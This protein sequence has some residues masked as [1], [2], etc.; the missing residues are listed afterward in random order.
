MSTRARAFERFRYISACALAAVSCTGANGPAQPTL[1]SASQTTLSPELAASMRSREAVLGGIGLSPAD[2]TF[3]GFLP[4]GDH[5]TFTFDIA[6]DQC[7]TFVALTTRNTRDADAALYT[8]DGELLAVDSETDSHPTIQACAPE[9]SARLYYVIQVVEGDGSFLV[10]P[11]LGTVRQLPAAARALGGRPAF[12]A[13]V[14]SSEL[15]NDDPAATLAEGLRKRGYQAIGES[16]V[17]VLAAKERIRT[18]LPVEHG[19]CYTVAAFGSAGVED[20]GL[21]VLDDQGQEVS[22]ADTSTGH[23]AAQLCARSTTSYSVESEARAGEGEVRLLTYRA[24]VVAAGGEAGLWLGRSPE[25]A[26]KPNA[27]DASSPIHD[28]NEL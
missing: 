26:A 15:Q 2:G 28:S 14:S 9:A 10:V 4:A 24:D 23:A 17:F 5:A 25:A 20:L 13:A 21:R 7:V 6:K 19:Q 16:R 27:S 1:T 8:A 12:A 22:A 11:F 18:P 3:S